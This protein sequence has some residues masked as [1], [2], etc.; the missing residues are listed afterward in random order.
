NSKQG[1]FRKNALVAFRSLHLYQPH[2][3]RRHEL[4]RPR[5][6]ADF[7]AQA[8][9]WLRCTQDSDP[10]FRTQNAFP[11]T[12]LALDGAI[13]HHRTRVEVSPVDLSNASRHSV[14]A[15]RCI[16]GSGGLSP[17]LRFVLCGPKLTLG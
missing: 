1:A 10:G 3:T 13:S 7:S 9:S 2:C 8:K 12:C 15:D 17:D 16:T 5:C 6:L 11:G 14:L 4:L